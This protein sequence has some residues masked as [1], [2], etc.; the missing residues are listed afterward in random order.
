MVGFGLEQVGELEEGEF[1]K[2][3]EVEGGDGGVLEVF[4][5]LVGEFGKGLGI[6][7]LGLGGRGGKRRGKTSSVGFAATFAGGP[8][9]VS[10]WVRLCCGCLHAGI[11]AWIFGGT[12]GELGSA[13]ILRTER[14]MGR[15]FLN[16]EG[17]KVAEVAEKRVLGRW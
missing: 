11:V 4:E 14:E 9:E 10:W 8:G 5:E 17:A 6:R 1:V 7:D 15:R 2:I 16:A 13:W 3:A 12:R